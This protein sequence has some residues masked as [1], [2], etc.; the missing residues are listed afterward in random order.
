MA[1]QSCSR[2]SSSKNVAASSA[3]RRQKRTSART[4]TYRPIVLTLSD[5]FE[6]EQ[7]PVLQ[8]GIDSFSEVFTAPE[9][10]EPTEQ[11]SENVPPHPEQA[12]EPLREKPTKPARKPSKRTS[13][14]STRTSTTATRIKKQSSASKSTTR[15]AEAVMF[16]KRPQSRRLANTPL[17]ALQQ[18]QPAAVAPVL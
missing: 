9:D 17:C 3:D 11:L 4:T 1:K 16:S 12:E 15:P 13:S 14:T 8:E 7:N 2:A 5:D 18:L 6:L 10:F